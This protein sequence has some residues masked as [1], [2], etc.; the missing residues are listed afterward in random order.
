VR[1]DPTDIAPDIDAYLRLL[2]TVPWFRNL[3]NAHP[4]DNTV[5]RIHAWKDWLGPERGFGDW[6]GRWQSVVRERI[7]ASEQA[8]L[9][10]LNALWKRIERLVVERAA[11]YVPLFDPEQD[12]WYGPTACV[13][14]AAYTACLVGWHILLNRT[15]PERLTSEWEWYAD[16]HW[17]CD[18]AEAPPGYRDDSIVD[19]ATG[20]L[21]VY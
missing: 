4:R 18:Y 20:K 12:A 8:R 1:R 6:F 14:G 2:E 16:G 11:A 13:W 3:G 9:A 10:E 5:F 19:L 17:P 15:L 21:L 7:E